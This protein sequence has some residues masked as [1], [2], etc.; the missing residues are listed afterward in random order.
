M[1]RRHAYLATMDAPVYTVPTADGS[2]TLYHKQLGAHYHSVHGAVQ[3]SMHIF[4]RNGLAQLPHLPEINILEMGF[5]TG[6][7]A[8]LTV[9]N[10]PNDIFVNYTSLDIYKISSQVT[11]ELKNSYPDSSLFEK[12][13]QSLWGASTAIAPGFMLNKIHLS[14]ADYTPDKLFHLCYFDAFAPDIQPELWTVEVFEKLYRCLHTGGL[15]LTYCSKGDVKR[16]LRQ[17]GFRVERLPGPPGKRHIIRA[18]K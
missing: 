3:E 6:L 16:A 13:H 8:L 11:Q 15:L 5:G 9:H 1:H 2:L 12:I 10:K 4:I 17:S 7:N 18:V 14:L